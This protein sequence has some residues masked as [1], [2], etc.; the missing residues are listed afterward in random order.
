MKIEI[1]A[2]AGED[3]SRADYIYQANSLDSNGQLIFKWYKATKDEL[4]SPCYKIAVA[5]KDYKVGEFVKPLTSKIQCEDNQ[6]YIPIVDNSQIHQDL[7]TIRSTLLSIA[8]LIESDAFYRAHHE[9]LMLEKFVREI[10]K[11][12]SNKK[13]L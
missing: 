2:Q 8:T 1:L 3:L 7:N 9:T 11:P 6:T 12:D 5:D 13:T 4:G 10:Q